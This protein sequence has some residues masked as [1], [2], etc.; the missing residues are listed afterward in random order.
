MYDR[1]LRAA[2]LYGT[3]SLTHPLCS[4]DPAFADEPTSSP[5]PS[6]WKSVEN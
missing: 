2:A 4:G 5:G 3:V 1:S 6:E